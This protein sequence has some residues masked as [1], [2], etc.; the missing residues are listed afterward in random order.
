MCINWN[1]SLKHW[2]IKNTNEVSSLVI[3][4]GN[5]NGKYQFLAIFDMAQG[6][7]VSIGRDNMLIF[8]PDSISLF[9]FSISVNKQI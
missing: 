3:L 5:G 2:A 1:C 9:S 7:N 6:S 8:L 4:I